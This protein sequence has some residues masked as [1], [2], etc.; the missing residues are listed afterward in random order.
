MGVHRKSDSAARKAK[1][2]RQVD[3]TARNKA[4]HIEKMKKDNPNYPDKKE[5][6]KEEA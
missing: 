3:R 1:Y 2:Q 6:K 5:T 4:K